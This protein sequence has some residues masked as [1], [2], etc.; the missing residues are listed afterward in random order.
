[1][2]NENN[3]QIN[4][5]SFKTL[6]ESLG[7]NIDLDALAEVL[8]PDNKY[9]KAAFIRVLKNEAPLNVAQ[10]E[11][12]ADY[13]NTTPQELFNYEN[14]SS[15]LEDEVLIFTKGSYT[16]KLNNPGAPGLALIYKDNKPVD[17]LICSGTCLFSEFITNIN[18]II[19]QLENGNNQN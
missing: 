12:L 15:K 10:L 1:M 14:W 8:F 18:N 11:L 13:L 4:K 5:F 6:V 19:K 3:M 17:K 16:V 2:K 7:S 9:P